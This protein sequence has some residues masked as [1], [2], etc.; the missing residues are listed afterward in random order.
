ME[1]KVR[2]FRHLLTR[3][4]SAGVVSRTI[5]GGLQSQQHSK[6]SVVASTALVWGHPPLLPVPLL[7]LLLKGDTRAAHLQQDLNAF[8]VQR[9]DDLLQLPCRCI[10]AGAG[11]QAWLRGEIADRRLIKWAKTCMHMQICCR[12]CKD[13]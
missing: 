2:I 3:P 4:Q 9:C 8:A 1:F 5:A 11:S 6:C 10:G 12:G 7:H 13:C